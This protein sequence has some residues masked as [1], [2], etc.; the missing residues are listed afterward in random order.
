MSTKDKTHGI[1]VYI[2]VITVGTAKARI[3][4]EHTIGMITTLR[5]H[6]DNAGTIYV[7]VEGTK[8]EYPLSANDKQ[9]TKADIYNL[10]VYASAVD[11][12]LCIWSEDDIQRVSVTK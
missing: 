6:P 8:K 11:Q 3:I 4:N 12:Y 10:W 5:A 9:V 1:D 2:D 7:F